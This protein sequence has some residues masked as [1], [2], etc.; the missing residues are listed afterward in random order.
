MVA[1]VDQRVSIPD[2]G[3]SSKGAVSHC[4]HTRELSFVWM[5]WEDIT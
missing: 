3:S 2:D 5:G 4:H 1:K